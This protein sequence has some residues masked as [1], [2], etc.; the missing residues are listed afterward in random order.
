MNIM[1]HPMY[2]H[3]TGMCEDENSRDDD[4]ERVRRKKKSRY[5]E[6]NTET[7]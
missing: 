1:L 2:L 5:N 3:C 6:K 7:C 4:E